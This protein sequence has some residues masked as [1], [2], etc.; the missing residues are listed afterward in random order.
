MM[1]WLL[2]S[3]LI[4]LLLLAWATDAEN[5]AGAVSLAIVGIV[6]AF[7]LTWTNPI[8]WFRD[9]FGNIMMGFVSWF[10]IG[11]AWS[12]WKWWRWF[13]SED[14]VKLIKT[15]HE[16]WLKSNG[17]EA[18]FEDS[19]YYHPFMLLNNKDRIVRWIV[20]W[21]ASLLWSLTYRLIRKTVLYVYDAMKAIYTKIAKREINRIISNK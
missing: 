5:D 3:E 4:I 11:A 12:A 8:D 6:L 20:F 16:A 1:T 14:T 21:P 18:T 2:V 9:N 7:F 17:S 13:R 19:S 15:E 10:V